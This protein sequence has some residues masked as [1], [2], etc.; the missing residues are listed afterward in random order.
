MA[1]PAPGTDGESRDVAIRLSGVTKEFP[2]ASGAAVD[3][4]SLDIE[5]GT[6]MA[7]LGPSGCGKT[8]TL[9]M[10]NRLI[11]P[12]SGTIEINGVDVMSQ[13]AQ[14][15]RR[16][17]GYVIQQV[18]LFPHRTIASNIATVPMMLG[19]D[20]TRCAARV[21]E[22]TTLVGLD[23]E[24]LDRYPD[25]LSGGQQQRV[26]VARALAADPPVLLMDEPFGAV[27]PIVRG[28]LQDELLD[29]QRKVSKTIVL[30]TH[31]VDE[32]L[33]V[34]DRIALMNIGGVVEQLA[35]PDELMRAPA[36]DFVKSF[37]GE[38]R[39]L[40]RLALNR[41][42]ALRFH[43]G[44]VVP[45][46]ASFDEAERAVAAEGSDW[47]GI[48]IDGR[49]AGWT[50]VGDVRAARERHDARRGR[51]L[52]P[53]RPGRAVEHPA[54]GDGADHVVELV[55]GGDRRRWT[56]RRRRHPGG[57]P[58]SAFQCRHPD[59]GR[60]GVSSGSLPSSLLA[61][62]TNP[63]IRWEW[64]VE[65][66]D[67]IWAA[68][69]EHL[70]LT[71]M[72]MALGLVV[73]SILAAIAL[74]YRWTMTP[75]TATTSLI[76]TLPSVAL[77]A[78]LAP[79]FG[80]L[81]RWTA[82]LPLAGYT[83]LILV[84]N[85]VAG[86]QA[87]PPSVRDSADGMGMSPARRM[88]SVDLPLAVPYIVTGIRIATVSTVG[89]VTVAAIIGQGGLGRLIFSG[90]RRAFWTPMTVG[91]SLSIILAL[92]L[93]AVILVIGLWLAPWQRRRRAAAP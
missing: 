62:A 85:I 86:F 46:E 76:Y 80:N 53:D 79:V 23:H 17:I 42:A 35:T 20:K 41:V 36:S 3:N 30:V 49:F 40:R 82:V 68:I 33:R 63:I 12:T 7:L 90:L 15:L 77:F 52:R 9:R 14:E 72:A 59:G 6:I 78:L 21:E 1:E 91:A 24:L 47:L 11:E 58:A 34:A 57:H 61:E 50:K 88:W 73:S 44:P 26:G 39:G 13:S 74:R 32:A 92:V 25:E 69:V 19:W 56:L 83:L 22:L 29:L 8:T 81:S 70:T 84:T 10:I 71:V 64:V 55:G 66:W 67:Q 16:G 89:L 4:L 28:R 54:S 60:H 48:T 18:G 37:V 31:D 93:D 5:R 45:V 43:Q 38:D 87:V 75:I 51:T 27:D 2:G 65:E